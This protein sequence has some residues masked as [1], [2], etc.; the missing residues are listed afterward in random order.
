MFS[1]NNFQFLSAY[2]KYL[3]NNPK[4]EKRKKKKTSIQATMCRR[5]PNKTSI[6]TLFSLCALEKRKKKGQELLLL[7]CKVD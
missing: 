1:D 6:C 3:L 5:G 7:N 2:T 4:K